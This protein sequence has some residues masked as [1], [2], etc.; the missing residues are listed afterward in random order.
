MQCNLRLRVACIFVEIHS[1]VRSCYCICAGAGFG[2][3]VFLVKYIVMSGHAIVF[4]RQEG[5]SDKDQGMACMIDVQ[6]LEYKT[7]QQGRPLKTG[8][9][10]AIS[11]P[12]AFAI[13]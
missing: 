4:L 2:C 3:H 12:A 11:L 9:Y 5:N 13:T 8:Q 1:N 10:F 6:R 7:V